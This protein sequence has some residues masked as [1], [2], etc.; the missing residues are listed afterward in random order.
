MISNIVS[1]CTHSFILKTNIYNKKDTWTLAWCRTA[2]L[3]QLSRTC[4]CTCIDYILSGQKPVNKPN[5]QL[6]WG[7]T[8]C[9][10]LN[11]SNDPNVLIFL[12]CTCFTTEQFKSPMWC[13]DSCQ[14]HIQNPHNQRFSVKWGPTSV[15]WFGDIWYNSWRVLEML[16]K[17]KL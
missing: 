6:N 14:R 7:K 12:L 2:Y 4:L 9:K 11:Y 17:W 15:D 5:A 10:G 13:L 3:S 16:N 1:G 8:I